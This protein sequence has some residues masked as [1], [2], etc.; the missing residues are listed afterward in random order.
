MSVALEVQ[1]LQFTA[2]VLGEAPEILHALREN[3]GRDAAQRFAIYR[4]AYRARLADALADSFGHTARFLGGDAFRELALDYIETHPPSAYSIRWYG[5]TLPG[6][7]RRVR[8]QDVPLAELAALDWALRAAFDSA[9]ATPLDAAVLAELKPEEWGRTGFRLHPSFRL[10]A[11]RWNTVAVWQALD[12]EETPPLA[13]A[14]PQRATLAVWRRGLQPHFRTLEAVEG[15][16]LSALR[17]GQSFAA[18]CAR[19]AETRVHEDAASLAGRW[20]RRWVEEGLLV[21]LR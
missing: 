12:R 6:W 10:L 19:L 4:E 13:Q 2:G 9:D 20:L 5:A 7:L 17:A 3:R 14:L 18:V 11:Q 8:A 21:A 16:A 15:S 1:Q